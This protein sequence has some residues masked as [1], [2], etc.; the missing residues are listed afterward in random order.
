[1][2]WYIK[3]VKIRWAKMGIGAS[4]GALKYIAIKKDKVA[5]IDVTFK[6][7]AANVGI[8]LISCFVVFYS[9]MFDMGTLILNVQVFHY[10]FFSLACIQ[11]WGFYNGLK[12]H[13]IN[14]IIYE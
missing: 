7:F 1:M 2:H 8:G 12:L 9:K 11:I 10:V 4:A 14:S 3:I 13:K 5:A 6:Q